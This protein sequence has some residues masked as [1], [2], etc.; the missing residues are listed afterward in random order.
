MADEST[1]DSTGESTH[2]FTQTESRGGLTRRRALGLG[3]VAAGVVAT[4][5][6]TRPAGATAPRAD[7]AP[8]ADRPDAA[9]E[10]L[11]YPA[12]PQGST[13]ARTLVHGTPGTLGY[14]RIVPGPGEPSVVRGDLL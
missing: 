2:E 6:L 10:P 8:D 14:R 12:A 9:P 11:A 7:A 3:A 1:Q 13:L 5:A 4:G